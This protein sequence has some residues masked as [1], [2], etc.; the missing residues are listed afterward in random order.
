MSNL[1]SSLKF[2]R[3]HEHLEALKNRKVIAPVHIRI[4]PT[5]HCNHDCWYCAYK[6]D[7]LQL[8][9]DIVEADVIPEKK[10]AEIV[11]DIIDMG[12]KAVTFSG[13]GEPLLYKTLPD[14]VERLAQGGVRV[15]TL[16]NGSNLKGRMADSLAKYGT[17]VRISIDAWDDLSYNKARGIKGDN[18]SQIVRNMRNFADKKS[19]C[20]LG[21]S[22]V[23]TQDNYKHLIEACSIFKNA[24]VNHVKLSAVVISNDGRKN[25]QYHG[26][27]MEEVSGLIAQA[28]KLNDENFTII[29]HYHE[30]DER[31]DKTYKTCSF[32]QFLTVIG[33]DC[34]V[35][36]CQ[37]KAYNEKGLLGSCKEQSFKDFWFSQENYKRIFSLDPT[38][39]CK[40]HC[41]SHGKNLA[42]NEF[43]DTDPDHGLFV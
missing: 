34:Q 5:N 19:P 33:A 3:F 4:K 27:I 29:N 2:L 6:V 31:F 23:V 20:V 42:I 24:G 39:D 17:W 37:D 22:F 1:Y 11:E 8:G 14:T 7:H 30:L 12:V 10:M 41:V 9:E 26:E 38:T 36:S 32:L 13:G 18:F 43:I 35:Y 21:V 28:Q 25:N 16:T 40:H 15:A